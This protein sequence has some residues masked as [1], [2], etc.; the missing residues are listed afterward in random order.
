MKSKAISAWKSAA[1]PASVSLDEMLRQVRHRIRR[2]R[3]LS[4]ACRSAVV[5]CGTA[6]ALAVASVSAF[7]VS[8]FPVSGLI[9]A[10][11]GLGIV[12]IATLIGWAM[13]VRDSSAAALIDSRYQLQD[14][15]VTA[16]QF[17]REVEQGTAAGN[18]QSRQLRNRQVDETQVRLADVDAAAC[19]PMRFNPAALGSAIAIGALAVGVLV[20]GRS[21]DPSKIAATPVA[22]AVDQAEEL[23]QTVL[24][25]LE[26]ASQT[27]D[28]PP[29]LEAVVEEIAELIEELAN[30]SIDEADMM[31]TLSEMEAALSQ[32]R[33]SMQMEQTDAQMSALA[34]AMQSSASMQAAAAAMKKG[35]YDDA[36]KKLEKIDPDSLG[37]KERRAVAD[38]LKK[39]LASL[40]P[41]Q[42]GKLSGAAKQLQEGLEKK[43]A[44]E[45]KS[46]M[47]K[48]ASLCKKQSNC[49]KIGQCM[50]CQLNRLSQC[51][52]QCRG[53]C[54]NGGNKTAK[55]DSPSQK[56]G[57][58]ATG[59]ANDGD[60]TELAS[61]RNQEKLQ[62]NAGDGPSESE[63]IQ[64]EEGEQEAAQAYS[65]RYA[66]FRSQAEA[67]LDSE[68]LPLGHRQTVRQYFEN[69][70]PSAEVL[71]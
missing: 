68:P 34:D 66:E 9:I 60:S 63:V 31:A 30:E 7:P 35:D 33:D 20:S 50:A 40:S 27:E 12:A 21:P 52:S 70:R 54:K 14:R 64:G 1:P 25:E 36:S 23:R 22:L 24:K 39:F 53:A 15:T 55:S 17:Q 8:A 48:L 11:V 10:M 26:V 61:Q 16:L 4:F 47:C 59:A 41:G 46:G 42:K 2:Q 28:A 19:V 45:C 18:Q 57:K 5:A 13:P 56:W 71:K 67:V 65:R 29:E 38:N 43:D 32:A 3:A 51:K 44:S 62:S 49:K 37:D 6:L 69:I 58:G